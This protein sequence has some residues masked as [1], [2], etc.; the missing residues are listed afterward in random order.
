MILSCVWMGEATVNNAKMI[1]VKHYTFQL[2]FSLVE[3]AIVLV[4]VG[5]LL[6]G[7]L[8]TISS[9]IEQ[10]RRNETRKQMEEIKESLVGFAIS[11]GY[12]PCPAVSAS[13]GVEDRSATAC[14]KRIGFV[15]WVTLGVS[16][17]DGWG[18]IFRYSATN[19]FTNSSAVFAT[20]T[21]RDITIK[22]R[23]ATGTLTN[24]SNTNDIPAVILSH[25]QNGIFGALD[26]GNI[27]SS[28]APS[29][30]NNVADQQTNSDITS[31][32]AGRIFLNRD[33]AGRTANDDEEFDDL[34]TWI[35]PVILYNRMVM[36]GKLP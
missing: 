12:L 9:Q 16:K 21:L 14:N 33:P 8:P 27:L 32:N 4:I 31:A 10:Q 19:A 28:T 11:K 23:D 36:A 5:L 24:L 7:L 3:M 34:V 22:T 15:P 25:G 29:T 2:G 20:V 30:F 35:S 18:R 26:N 6:A 13:S 1:S 17:T